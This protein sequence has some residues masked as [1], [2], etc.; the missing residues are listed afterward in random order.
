VLMSRNRLSRRHFVAASAGA[1]MI[2]TSALA[3]EASPEA[4]PTGGGEGAE[5]GSGLSVSQ[6]GPVAESLG[7]VIPEELGPEINWAVEGANLQQTRE[8]LGSNISSETVGE[9]G[10]AWT[11]QY[12]LS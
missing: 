4:T 9:L 12:D 11:A 10:T 7:P 3:Q 2:G 6:I 8:A 5:G 1:A